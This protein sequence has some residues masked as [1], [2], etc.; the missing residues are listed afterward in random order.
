MPWHPDVT[1]PNRDRKPPGSFAM[2]VP[3]EAPEGWIVA[4]WFE[5]E[6]RTFRVYLSDL[7]RYLFKKVPDWQ[8]IGRHSFGI[9]V[10]LNGHLAYV[11]E[12]QKRR[13]LQGGDWPPPQTSSPAN[14]SPVPWRP[15]TL[16][17]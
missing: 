2:S 9:P 13:I 4:V 16:P 7:K 17:G 8:A 15:H 6:D 3:W 12:K 5:P 10:S 1:F 11:L 14:Q